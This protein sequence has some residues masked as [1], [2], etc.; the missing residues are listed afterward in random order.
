MAISEE[1]GSPRLHTVP[2]VEQSATVAS[3]PLQSHANTWVMELAVDGNLSDIN[4]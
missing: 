4:E 2:T 1:E 3:F